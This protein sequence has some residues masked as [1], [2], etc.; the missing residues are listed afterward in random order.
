MTTNHAMANGGHPPSFPITIYRI[1]EFLSQPDLLHSLVTMIN[2]AYL[3]HK[4]FEAGLR[5][6]YDLQ[7]V[8]HLGESGICAVMHSGETIVATASLIKWR[9]PTGGPVDEAL[10]VSCV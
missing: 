6:E 1:S 7:M 2:N 8:E 10:K 5:F 4:E 3:K 9:P